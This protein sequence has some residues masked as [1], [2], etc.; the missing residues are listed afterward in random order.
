[1][2]ASRSSQAGATPGRRRQEDRSE[3]TRRRLIDATLS[4]LE[5]EGYAGTTISKIVERADVSRG[6]H[7]HH[8]PSKAALIEAAARQLVKGIYI[9]LGKTLATLADSDDKLRA[10]V[11]SSW[12][13][14][15]AA[16]EHA[17]LL[18]LLQASRHDEELAAIMQRLWQA[19]Y[20]LIKGA[21]EHYFEPV[22]A[23]ADLAS[24]F[25][26]LQWQLRG[27]ALDIH[28]HRDEPIYER[29][30]AVW[31]DLLSTHVRA[32][33]GVSGPPPRPP[34]WVF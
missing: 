24:V 4:C 8:F 22:H 21:A 25:V 10:L 15:F 17:V 6:A 5:T 9:Q 23:G 2:T 34:E 29:H 18:E 20:R 27:M 30:I 3:A 28:L 13:T 32:R 33:H 14:V 19:G 26:L 31:C 11:F 7:V 1:M 16:R 12:R